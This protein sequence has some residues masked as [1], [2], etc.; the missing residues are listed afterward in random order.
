MHSS[1]SGYA[2]G[3]SQFKK[4]SIEYHPL[5][6]EELIEAANYY[7]SRQKDLGFRFLNSIEEALK[8]LQLNPLMWK[9]F[10]R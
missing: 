4:I 3:K 6:Y 8:L 5:A 9:F 2:K 1:R 7:E 10:C